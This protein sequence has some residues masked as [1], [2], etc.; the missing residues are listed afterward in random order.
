MSTLADPHVDPILLRR[1]RGEFLEMPGLQ[2]TL[3][4]ACRLWNLD[5]ATSLVALEALVAEAFLRRAGTA[6]LLSDSG[7]RCA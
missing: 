6:Y 7:R 2:L 5:P 4:Q 1:L 3:P